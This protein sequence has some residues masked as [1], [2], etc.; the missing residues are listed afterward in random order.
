MLFLRTTSKFSG[1]FEKSSLHASISVVERFRGHFRE[2]L[3][4]W[5][6]FPK[7]VSIDCSPHLPSINDCFI[8]NSKD[9]KN[10]VFFWVFFSVFRRKDPNFIVF[11]LSKKNWWKNAKSSICALRQHC[12]SEEKKV[13]ILISSWDN[14]ISEIGS[15]LFYKFF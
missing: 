4:N 12:F 9:C 14:E 13:N 5:V 10:R 6:I 1:F 11:L 3:Q 8:E 15:F 2:Q 7:N